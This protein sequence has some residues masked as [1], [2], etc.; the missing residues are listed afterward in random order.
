MTSTKLRDFSSR[1][2][3]KTY[4]GVGSVSKYNIVTM[5]GNAKVPNVECSLKDTKHYDF[6]YFIFV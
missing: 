5:N 3:L 4:N 1:R 2:C 6:N